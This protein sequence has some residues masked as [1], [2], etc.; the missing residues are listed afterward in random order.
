MKRSAC[1]RGVQHTVEHVLRRPM[2]RTRFVQ[3]LGQPVRRLV[4]QVFIDDEFEAGIGNRET[5]FR[6]T[7]QRARRDR[8]HGR[9]KFALEFAGNVLI[10]RQEDPR[11][12]LRHDPGRAVDGVLPHDHVA[13]SRDGIPHRPGM[14]ML[15][16]PAPGREIPVEIDAVVLQHD[17]GVRTRTRREVE[18]RLFVRDLGERANAQ[19]GSHQIEVVRVRADQAREP[20]H[21]Q[22][23]AVLE[24]AAPLR[25]LRR[26]GRE[27]DADIR[28]AVD[29]PHQRFAPAVTI[30]RD[31][32][33]EPGIPKAFRSPCKGQ[34]P[35][36]AVLDGRE[37]NRFR[38]AG[39]V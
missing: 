38:H 9:A 19:I 32:N 15:D 17:L 14:R 10:Q 30:T 39:A 21:R 33:I 16:A 2:A 28:P 11:R 26:A 6:L 29:N 20:A 4:R 27:R 22:R 1:L 18:L 12:D 25:R 35:L 7:A 8:D 34:P 36:A 37:P 24:I 5:R 3:R 31:I 13:F 23:F